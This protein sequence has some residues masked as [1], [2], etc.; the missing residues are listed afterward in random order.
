MRPIT[1][2]QDLPTAIRLAGGLFLL[3]ILAFYALA[4]VNLA[5]SAGAGSLPGPSA[6]LAKYHGTRAGSRLHVVLDPA[7]PETD[8][9]A[10]YPNLGTTE[11]ERAARRAR[12]LGWVEA[13][14][15]A[16][17]WPDVAPVFTAPEGCVRCH[18]TA[19]GG[20]RVQ[21][22][23]PLETY[24][25][26]LP[27][28]SIDTGMAPSTLALTSHNHLMG[29]AV[30]ALL[31]SCLVALTRWPRRLVLTLV[32]IVFVGPVID[33]ASWWLTHSLGHPF[34]YGVILGG[35][36]FGVGLTTM[37]ILVLDELW[38]RSRVRRLLAYMAPAVAVPVDTPSMGDK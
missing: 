30:A 14:A 38:L 16:S 18:S 23:L 36:L 2:L 33:V 19:E 4:Q 29:F 7:R 1:T 17:G 13:G 5:L 3:L 22:A 37:A 6:V 20:S 27:L 31:V 21:A 26:V 32:A 12:I 34:E 24:E 10:M 28:A 8:P 11:A 9:K 25:Q 35:A 15:L